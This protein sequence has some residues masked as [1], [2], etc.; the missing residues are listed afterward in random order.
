MAFYFATMIS[1]KSIFAPLNSLM[2]MR[3]NQYSSCSHQSHHQETKLFRKS[4]T[5]NGFLLCYHD[6]IQIYICSIE[7]LDVNEEESILIL[8]TSKSSP[9]NEVISEIKHIQ[10]LFTLLP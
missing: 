9:R 3:K 10:W 1:F 4:N 6:F 7:F 8:F 5:Y 2:S